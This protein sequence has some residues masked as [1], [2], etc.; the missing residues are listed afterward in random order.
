[1]KLIENDVKIARYLQDTMI[2][3]EAEFL[4]ELSHGAKGKTYLIT[5]WETSQIIQNLEDISIS[6]L[7]GFLSRNGD[8]LAEIHINN[9]EHAVRLQ[10]KADLADCHI[11]EEPPIAVNAEIRIKD[12]FGL[13]LY[14]KI[15]S[16]SKDGSNWVR[17]EDAIFGIKNSLMLPDDFI[18]Q[19]WMAIVENNE[20]IESD[21]VIEDIQRVLG[22]KWIFVFSSYEDDKAILPYFFYSR[23]GVGLP[24]VTE[25]R[26]MSILTS[27]FEAL[28]NSPEFR[29]FILTR[30]LKSVI[31]NLETKGTRELRKPLFDNVKIQL[32]M[33]ENLVSEIDGKFFIR[34]SVSLTNL[35]SLRNR[36]L[37][38]SSKLSSEWMNRIVHL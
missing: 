13:L 2:I 3:K 26:L 17:K 22:R 11:N 37:D 10:T 15:V 20:P 12:A 35:E 1:M 34:E 7:E 25:E 32:L 31:F 8:I 27:E 18:P 33:D 21:R 14:K 23:K 19:S 6:E 9:G 30:I 28:R 29:I 5:P 24:E 38:L 16:L 36:Y 4:A